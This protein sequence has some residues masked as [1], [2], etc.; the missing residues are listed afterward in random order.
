M[1]ER[2]D[3]QRLDYEDAA[4]HVRFARYVQAHGLMCQECGGSGEVV[5]DRVDFGDDWCGSIMFDIRRSC[6]YC[7][8]TGRVTRWMRG[9]WLRDM[10]EWKRQ[11][12]RRA[13]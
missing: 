9:A 6:G 4:H 8:G 2:V 13:A 10:R 5:E 1:T 7:E 3:Y 12:E 11:R